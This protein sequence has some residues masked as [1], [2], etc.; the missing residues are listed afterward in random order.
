MEKLYIQSPY[1]KNV[2]DKVRL[3]Y[4]VITPKCE[5]PLYFEV[6]KEYGKYLVTE[7]GDAAV[8]C[9]LLYAMEHNYH[10]ECDVPVSERL[11][12]QLNE[13]LIPAISKNIKRYHKIEI[14]ANTSDIEFCGCGCGTG[15]SCGVDSFY[16][17]LK[18]L[19]HGAGSKLQLTHLCF[20]NAGATGMFGG[21]HAR[22]V[23]TERCKRFR[24]VS[25][26]LGCKFVSC[27][28]NMNEFLLQEHEKTHI[29]R[30][31]CIPLA[32]QKLFGIYYFSST[33]EY[34]EFKF[35]DFDPA[36]YEILILPNLSNQ[37][38]RFVEVGGEV[39]RQ[40]KVS[41]ISN[42]EITQEELNVCISGI[43]NCHSCRKCRRTMLNL[44]LEGKLCLYNSVF[45]VEWFNRNKHAMFRWA[46][47]NFW[48]VDMPEIIKE[49]RNKK[50]LKLIDYFCAICCFPI[51]LLKQ[52]I[53]KISFINRKK[54]I[55]NK[56]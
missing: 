9:V 17:V 50:E 1:I 18:N 20:F 35:T 41:Y 45:D 55:I 27:D 46:I 28:S 15:L 43:E 47:M 19:E 49:L 30:T 2:S 48:R 32:L 38:I 42:F 14:I 33:Y 36:Y 54:R 24:K 12:Y 5:Y 52:I 51:S 31:L 13:Y 29:F 40:G 34:A 23:F 56:Q 21:E 16:S 37:N 10:V 26:K 22:Q 11:M 3:V 53:G 4:N 8:V 25:D 44:Y 6:D 39:T 7:L